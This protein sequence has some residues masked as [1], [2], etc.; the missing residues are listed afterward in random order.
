ML[1]LAF[2]ALAL[3]A[4]A[5]DPQW[6]VKLIPGALPAG[7]AP[8]GNTIIFEDEDGLTVVD[9]GR[10]L[11]HQAKILDYARQRGKPITAIVNTH[12]HLDHSG[13][14]EEIRAVYPHAKLYTSMA[15]TGAIKGYLAQPLINARKKLADPAVPEADKAETRLFVGA[16]DDE[17]D[18]IPDMPVTGDSKLG[19]L[20]LHSSPFGSTEADT[21]LVDPAS[22]TAV[23]GD[24]IVIPLPF[25]DSGCAKGWRAALDRIA[26]ERFDSVIPGHGP[27]L[28]RAQFEIYRAAFGK[29]VDCAA[30]ADPNQACIDGWLRDAAPLLSESD[31]Q[32][33]QDSLGYYIDKIIRVPAKQAELCGTAS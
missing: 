32:D 18:L 13:G 25:F 1:S 27:I 30:G 21:W 5:P 26:R 19:R 9:T 29:F 23:V 4:A 3:T 6:P 10:H 24:L 2:A 31:R 17:K 14:N 16:M 12:W 15:V 20:E 8:D 7:R 33:V 28:S 22:R 11:D